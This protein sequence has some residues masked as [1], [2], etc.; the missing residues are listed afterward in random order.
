MLGTQTN[1]HHAN[2]QSWR[3]SSEHDRNVLRTT[4]EY[5]LRGRY[6]V[7]MTGSSKWINCEFPPR[8][9]AAEWIFFGLDGIPVFHW[10]MERESIMLIG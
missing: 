2:I 6:S 8:T 1:T 4:T 5:N 7:R 9:G 3:K 10:S